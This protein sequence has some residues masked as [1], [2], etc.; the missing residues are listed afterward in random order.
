MLLNHLRNLP[1]KSLAL[2]DG[3]LNT[4]WVLLFIA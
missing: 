3:V 2:S 1:Y 4:N